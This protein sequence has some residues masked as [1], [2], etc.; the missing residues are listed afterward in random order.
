MQK[1]TSKNVRTTIELVL[2]IKAKKK[3]QNSQNILE[4]KNNGMNYGLK[5]LRGLSIM[6][7]Q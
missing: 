2:E 1:K 6:H 4:L 3:V 5:W 7:T